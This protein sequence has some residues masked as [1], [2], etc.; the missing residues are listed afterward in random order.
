MGRQKPDP[1]TADR[2]AASKNQR[3]DGHEPPAYRIG[4]MGL[5]NAVADQSRHS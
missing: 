1:E 2:N 4:E 5:D 3:P